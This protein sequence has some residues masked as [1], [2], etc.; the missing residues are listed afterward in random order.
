MMK[1]YLF[2]FFLFLSAK[3]FGQNTID[4]HH[5]FKFTMQNMEFK[6]DTI[7]LAGTLLIPEKPY[8]AVVLVHGSGQEKRMIKL[9]STLAENGIAVFTYDKRG[10]GESGGVYEGPEVGTNNIDSVNLNRLATDASEALNTLLAHLPAKPIPVGLMGFS[11]AGWIVPLAAAKNRQVNFMV[12]FSG[13]VVNTLQQLRFQFYTQGDSNFWETHTENDAWNHIKNDPDRYSFAATDPNQSLAML[14]IPGLWI[15][16]GKDIQAP[17]GLSI[18]NLHTF[19]AKGKLYEY[20]LYPE[21]GHNTAFST[22]EQ[23]LKMAISW[24]KHRGNH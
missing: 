22:S 20:A 7:T 15:F 11:Q 19:K 5:R 13:P 16:G 4:A 8:A 17:V 1:T 14:N 24:I 3:T 23:P 18:E 6:R 9:A 21:L 2:L 10:V 12:L